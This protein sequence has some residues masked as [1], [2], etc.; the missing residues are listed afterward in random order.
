M[1]RSPFCKKLKFS[2]LERKFS[3][4]FI[5][6]EE[7]DRLKQNEKIISEDYEPNESERDRP[8]INRRNSNPVC[9]LS[10]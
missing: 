2:S 8:F 9:A 10:S 1:Q 3:Y 5:Q 7:Y 6:E 4:A